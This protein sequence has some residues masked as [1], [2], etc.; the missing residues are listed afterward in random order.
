MAGH[1]ENQGLRHASATDGGGF[2]CDA[3]RAEFCLRRNIYV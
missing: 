1:D 3:L 2:L